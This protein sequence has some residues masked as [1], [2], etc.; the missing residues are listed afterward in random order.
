MTAQHQSSYKRKRGKG[1]RMKVAALASARSQESDEGSK[2]ELFQFLS[3][4]ICPLTKGRT[5]WL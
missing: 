5:L 3:L 2:K 4:K 1:T